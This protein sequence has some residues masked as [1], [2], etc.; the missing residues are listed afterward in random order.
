[1]QN[2]RIAAGVCQID[3]EGKTT[4]RLRRRLCCVFL[5]TMLSAC[6]T[7]LHE[8][9]SYRWLLKKSTLTEFLEDSSTLILLLEASQ[10]AIYR[11][12]VLDNNTY[13][14]LIQPPLRSD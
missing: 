8:F 2:P 14:S 5:N 4:S 6:G 10:C 13:H 3:F 1:M 12:V 11:F 9:A 7:L